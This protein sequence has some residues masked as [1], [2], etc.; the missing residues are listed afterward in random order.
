MS[1]NRYKPYSNFIKRDYSRQQLSTFTPN[2]QAPTVFADFSFDTVLTMVDN[3]PVARGAVNHFVDKCMEGD[4]SIIT[5][6]TN[7]YDRDT[8]LTLDE[9]YMFRTS[10]LRKA[11]LMAKLF[12]N[13]FIEIIRDTEGRTKSLNV[14][15]STEIDPI[16]SPNGDPISYRSKTPSILTGEYV[17][18]SANDIVWIKFND[19][20]T[21][22]APV[23][24]KALWE[25]LLAKDYLRQYVGWLWKTGQYRL[26]Y[27]FKNSAS[28]KDVVDFL[29]YLRKNEENP[30]APLIAKGEMEAKV[31]RDMK[32]TESLVN[33]FDY[34]DNQTLILLRVPPTDAGV[35]DA[36][37][38]AS[39]DSQSNNFTTSVVAL[40]KLVEDYVNFDLFKKINKG[41]SLLRFAPADRFF[42]KKV[43][44]GVQ[45]LKSIGFSNEGIREYLEDN[46]MYFGT[47]KLLEDI[48]DP[49][50]L[51]TQDTAPSRTGKGSSEG[52]KKQETVSTRED[53]VKK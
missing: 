47:E 12:N 48:P 8:E 35:R 24:L 18:W 25:N 34:Y 13:V 11:F 3:D 53:Q 10:I 42:E 15:D 26:I 36:S 7:K 38:R 52:N 2:T 1:S 39:S 46:G 30:S 32:E 9:K 37:G 22:F 21:G 17:T 41:N 51:L 16:T 44:E 19:R 49:N 31:L 43:F 33:L 29:V 28:D 14:L 45:I 5:K 23:D 27:N 20:N 4:Y 40:R 50:E 6:D